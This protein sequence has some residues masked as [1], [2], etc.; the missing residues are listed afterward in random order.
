MRVGLTG[1]PLLVAAACGT[2]PLSASDLRQRAN[3]ICSR[4]DRQIAAIANPASQA[5]GKAFLE[6]GVA[7][8]DPELPALKALT[9]PS[10]ESVVYQSALSALSGEL[11]ALH[12]AVSS[13]NRGGDPV[14]TFRALQD[15]LGPLEAQADNAWRALGVQACLSRS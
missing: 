12:A 8:L 7:A 1:L 9:P 15:K 2:S 13:L 6:Q 5:A 4:A 10:D 3:A 14:K 11:D